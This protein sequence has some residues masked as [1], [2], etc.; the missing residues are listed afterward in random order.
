[1]IF[2]LAS[3]FHVYLPCLVHASGAFNKE[4]ALAG[5][6]KTSRTFVYSSK[7]QPQQRTVTGS[8]QLHSRDSRAEMNP[9]LPSFVSA[10]YKWAVTQISTLQWYLEYYLR[11]PADDGNGSQNESPGCHGGTRHT[12]HWLTVTSCKCDIISLIIASLIMRT[13]H[14]VMSYIHRNLHF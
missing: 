11:C 6:V 13:C 12:S 14:V 8:L 2:T 1:M 9:E 7:P 5:T 4:K 10:K 3:Q